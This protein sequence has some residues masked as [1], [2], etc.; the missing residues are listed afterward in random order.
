MRTLTCLLTCLAVA[1]GAINPSIGRTAVRSVQ[2][3]VRAR[4]ANDKVVSGLRV[5][6][7][8]GSRKRRGT[9][10]H[11]RMQCPMCTCLLCCVPEAAVMHIFQL[12]AMLCLN[13]LLGC[14]PTSNIDFDQLVD[15]C[16]TLR[17]RCC[18]R[19]A[20]PWKLH[21]AKSCG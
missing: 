3:R 18:C 5:E 17:A 21:L 15:C 10:S 6:A 19:S 12:H 4:F 9:V 14:M 11:V 20:C 16:R 2:R 13:V 7:V 1:G 8:C